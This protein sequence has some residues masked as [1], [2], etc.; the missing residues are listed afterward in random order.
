MK[1]VIT[2][3]HA[4][5][6]A[7]GTLKED[8]ALGDKLPRSAAQKALDFFAKTVYGSREVSKVSVEHQGFP[9]KLDHEKSPEEVAA[10][11]TENTKRKV[12]ANKVRAAERKEKKE[13]EKKAKAAEAQKATR[14]Q[15][16]TVT[17]A[18]T[19]SVKKV[20]KKTKK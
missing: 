12:E 15:P 11:G 16:K 20:T 2:I 5:G 8:F 13:N 17:R 1:T 18:I 4:E 14:R 6:Q 10:E 3:E 7:P 9:D 19:E